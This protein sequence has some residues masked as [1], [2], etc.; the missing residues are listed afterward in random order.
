LDPDPTPIVKTP[1][2][3][4]NIVFDQLR[5]VED[6]L[7]VVKS[8]VAAV[9]SAGDSV[10]N[11][12]DG[13][14]GAT[15]H[16]LALAV[17]MLVTNQVKLLSVVV[18]SAGS[19]GISRPPSYADAATLGGAVGG[20]SA[21]NRRPGTGGPPAQTPSGNP[22][23][24]KIRQA[25]LKAEKSTV[26]YNAELGNVP[27]MNRDTLAR[28]VT[29][30]LHEKARSEGEYKD[31]PKFAEEAVD[32]FLSCASL[33]FLGRG[34]KPFYNRKN[35]ED[36]MN[37]TFCTVP[38]KLTWKSKEER[39]RGEQAIRRI[40][41]SK[42]STPYPRKIRGLIDEVLKA[43]Q[44]AKPGCFIRIKVNHDSLTVVAHAREDNKW[45][46]LN[47]RKVIPLDI[48]DPAE[49]VDLATEDDMEDLS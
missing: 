49:L 20:G 2:L 34:T 31:N 33:D 18:D 36:P 7:S 42:C 15:V 5:E 12:A 9:M 28:K 13:G 32:D 27:V 8:T 17:D 29:I 30:L 4:S 3:D 24:K 41:K 16:K 43:G 19:G 47:L 46:D 26:I 39:I 11:I 23:E 1:R 22:R 10:F 44:A 37:K 38:I 14:L 45:I 21:G 40:C 6:N 35:P 25:I 48:L